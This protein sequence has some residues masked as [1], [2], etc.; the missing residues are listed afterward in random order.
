M[1]PNASGAPNQAQNPMPG[2]TGGFNNNEING[3]S[4]SPDSTTPG[5]GPA[6]AD[7]TLKQ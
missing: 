3:K 6:N 1:P 5:T 4:R 2:A 7:P